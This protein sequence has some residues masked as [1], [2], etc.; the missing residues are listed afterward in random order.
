MKLPTSIRCLFLA[1]VALP[2]L[3]LRAE[4]G[5]SGHY[6][7]GSMSSFIDSVPGQEAFI[8][9]FNTVFYQGSISKD[10]SLPFAGLSAAGADAEMF[11]EGLTVLW[12]PSWGDLGSNWSYAMSATVPFVWVDVKAGVDATLPG[13]FP[14]RRQISDSEEG[15]GDVVLMPL[16]LNYKA[17]D[18]FNVNFRFGVYAPTGE[19]EVGRLANPGK[20]YWSFEPT[21]GLM[22]FG[23]KTGFEASLFAGYTFNTENEDTRYDSGDQFHLDGTLAQHFP[24]FGGLCGVGI[25]GYWYEQVTGDEGAGARLGDFEGRTAGLG[26]VLSWTKKIG[27]TDLLAEVKWLSELETKKRLEGDTIWFKLAF[28]F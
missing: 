17:S 6:L 11:G 27:N 3:S 24:L 28:K 4:E 22:Y 7:P 2:A 13:G 23:Q 9:R 26:P 19:Y 25:S 1:L 14:L 10:I 12:R 15:L 18:D 20:N 5:G 16:M 21:L 8:A